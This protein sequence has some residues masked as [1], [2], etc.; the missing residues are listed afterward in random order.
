[1][2]VGYAAL[3]FAVA[4]RNGADI[5]AWYWMAPFVMLSLVTFIVAAILHF[6][7]RRPAK[8]LLRKVPGGIALHF[9]LLLTMAAFT[10]YKPIMQQVIP[11]WTDAPLAQIDWWLHFGHHPYQLIPHWPPLT[12]F[13]DRAYLIVWFGL[14]WT[15]PAI[16]L[17]LFQ[18]RERAR[19]FVAFFLTW[20]LLGTLL[21]TLLSSAGPVYAGRL[22]ITDDFVPLMEYLRST[23][24][25]ASYV[26]EALWLGYTGRGPKGG[27]SAMPSM[28]VAIA[29]LFTLTV[30][31]WRWVRCAGF[32]FTALVVVGSVHLGW[33]YAVDSYISIAGVWLIWR[34]ADQVVPDDLMSDAAAFRIARPRDAEYRRGGRITA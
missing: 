4:A 3:T 20:A 18:E 7:A 19:A 6:N 10:T 29:A 21:A 16:W 22:G 2:A 1:M 34:V 30:W 15:V 17:W 8:D 9:A 24:L 13:I 33:H 28:H 11:F 14:L 12:R 31:R 32:A 25:S 5:K 23:N 26:Q 27:I